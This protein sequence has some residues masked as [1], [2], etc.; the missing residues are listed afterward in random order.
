MNPLPAGAVCTLTPTTPEKAG[1]GYLSGDTSATKVEDEE[2]CTLAARQGI[3]YATA[4][5]D[6][7]SLISG[8]NLNGGTTVSDLGLNS[9]IGQVA[10]SGY[11]EINT[12]KLDWQINPKEHLS[13]LYHR[14]RWDSPGG[15]QTTAAD[16]Y[17]RDTQG[18]DFVKL[19][20]GVAKLTS[21][22]TN[23]I[24]NELLYQFGRENNNE[25]QQP[26]TAY[27]KADLVGSGTSAGN[28]P[29]VLVADSSTGWG[30]AAGSP[31]YSYRTYYPLEYKWQVGDV[32]YWNKGNHSMKFG[33]DA[34]HNTDTQNNLYEGNGEYV[35][36]YLGQYMNDLLNEKNGTALA[37]STT[38]T[39]YGCDA[40]DSE[41]ATSA[42]A[43]VING[44][45]CYDDFYQG[46]GTAAYTLATMDTGVFAQDNWKFSPR[47]TLELG[48]RWDY[49]A[50]P[51]PNPAFT[52]ANSTSGSYFYSY[53]GLTNHPS[54]K[55]NFGPRIGFSYDVNGKGNTVVRG[56]YGMYYGRITNG[57]LL[58]VLFDTGS[59]NAQYSPTFYNAPSGSVGEGP[60]FPN[61]FATGAA[62]KPTSYF[63]S[64]N[65]RNP[66]VQEFDL[67][68]QRN[69][70][71]GTY[72]QGSY[73][74]AL[75]RELP[76]FLDVNLNPSSVTSKTFTVSDTSAL[77]P[78]GA[79]G[80][81]ITIPVVYT[82]FGNTNMFGTNAANFAAITE[83]IS[84][85]NSN[86]NAMVLEVLN[87]TL[88]SLQFDVNYTWSHALDY[89]QNAATEGSTNAWY[90]PLWYI[91]GTSARI[92]YGDSS[93]NVPNRAVAYAL[94]NFPNIHSDNWVKY[95]TNDWSMNNSFQFQNGLPYTLGINATKPSGGAANYLNGAGGSNVIPSIGINTRRYP[96]RE[97]DDVR[98]Q[99]QVTLDHGRNLQ[100]MCNIFNVA[101]HQNITALGTTAYTL[102]SLSLT[103]QGQ[104]TTT[105]NN[106]LGVPTNSNSSGF[107]YTPR[108]VEFAVRI[109]F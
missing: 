48:L 60:V 79:T 74:G 61:I 13:V 62:A 25:S 8:G 29:E 34:V 36:T 63:F 80:S 10:R 70:G 55:M 52:T 88:H 83:M 94:L 47:L 69:L 37:S 76:N 45:P 75:G 99:K 66:Q 90:D 92:N 42:T 108:E 58:E 26:Y 5:A 53:P 103:Y 14:L 3:S 91:T 27:T 44:Y 46:F 1:N 54:D 41:Y 81:T 107:L 22:I 35:Y 56:G 84:N 68:V 16:N 49:E 23:N 67:M 77:G 109:N 4:A 65:L 101:N 30:F 97:V 15:V 18:M 57:N 87:R 31:Y 64:P 40:N 12:P 9:D 28:V 105:S 7:A 104:Y 102:S 21:L 11:Q 85:V 96:H 17:A 59:A 32:L 50:L 43:T 38:A 106:S 24:S 95:L 72:I 78:L 51:A 39:N 100:L 19:D 2:A 89:S 71:H 33:V 6:W 98:F 20:Y 73:L 86:Y 82:G 93:Y